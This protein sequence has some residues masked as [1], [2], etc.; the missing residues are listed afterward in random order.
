MK[1]FHELLT[2]AVRDIAEHGYDSQ[3][4]LD[5]W[6]RRLRD[7]AEQDTPSVEE[8]RQRMDEALRAIYRRN[9]ERAA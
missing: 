6:M 8:L 9:V 4:R 2:E 5:R 1:T 3:E 7:A